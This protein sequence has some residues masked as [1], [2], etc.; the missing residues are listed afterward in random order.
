MVATADERHADHVSPAPGDKRPAVLRTAAMYGANGHGKSNFVNSAIALRKLIIQSKWSVP[1]FKLDPTSADRPSRMVMEYRHEGFDYEYGVVVQREYIAEE[2]LF[3]TDSMGKE[4]A[5]F[6]RATKPDDDGGYST[7]VE[8]GKALTK[9]KSPVRD[10]KMATYIKVLATGMKPMRTFLAEAAE[11]DISAI[12]AAH[13]WF[14]DILTPVSATASYAPLYERVSQETEFRAFLGQ[15]MQRIDVGI[16]KITG[17]VVKFDAENES[18]LPKAL[19]ERMAELNNAEFFHIGVGDEHSMVVERD[20]DGNIIIRE[21]SAERRDSAGDLVTFGM[22]EESSG[23]RRMLDLA[24]MLCDAEDKRVYLVD[25]LDRKL[26]PLLAY[27]FVEEFIKTTGQQLIFT[28]HNTFL[29][30]L[31]LLRRDEV[32]FVQKRD[33]GSSTIYSLADMKIRPDLNIRKG[34]LNGRFGAIPFLG[35]TAD[36][37]WAEVSEDSHAIN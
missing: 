17:D 13:Y 33:D 15:F 5:L 16:E 22:E 2:W 27:Q 36:L 28:T 1:K 23:T 21:I 7:V 20:D 3:R 32:W 8:P 26:H 37:G 12:N 9:E 4:L 6:E 19:Q 11:R 14:D 35:N 10:V 18:N 24:P 31:D 25:E 30:S 34:Y 29:M